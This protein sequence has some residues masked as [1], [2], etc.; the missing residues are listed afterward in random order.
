MNR[1]ET[2]IVYNIDN[3]ELIFNTIDINDITVIPE[4]I[5]VNVDCFQ[6][7][8]IHELLSVKDST[9]LKNFFLPSLTLVLQ[10]S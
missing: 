6:I 7:Y 5:H 8:Q 9:E 4:I 2:S 3:E 1:F 10:K